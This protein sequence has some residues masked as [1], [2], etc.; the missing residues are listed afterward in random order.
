MGTGQE[1][2]TVLLERGKVRIG[3]LTDKGFQESFSC[4]ISGAAEAAHIDA[5]DLDG[6]GQ[7]ELVV[8]AVE[9]GMPASML[10]RLDVAS[11]TCPPLLTMIR[12]SLRVI[13]M[14]QED[15]SAKKILAGQ[16]W[17]SQQFFQGKVYEMEWDL[18]RLREKA[19]IDLPNSV[20]LY[21]FSH[22]LTGSDAA[23]V[24][25]VRGNAPLMVYEQNGRKW[26]RVWRS[27]NRFGGTINALVASQRPLLDQESSE[28]VL[29]AIPP[30][31]LPG[32][33]VVAVHHDIPLHDIVGRRTYI[34]AADLGAFTPDPALGYVEAGVSKELP[35]AVVTLLAN[36]LHSKGKLLVLL[37]ENVGAFESARGSTLLGFTLP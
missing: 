31:A 32:G 5:L 27:G 15:G 22:L 35:G 36:R 24:A 4:P 1:P 17:S 10:L 20:N 3:D 34:R 26:R 14:P 18:R 6:D 28:D 19:R 23:R 9:N 8:A 29:F 25:V 7:E 33:A 21:D 2:R 12:Y 16:G 13:E 37:Q 11:K 30:V